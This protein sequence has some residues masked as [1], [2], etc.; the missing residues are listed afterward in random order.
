M[1]VA[2][3]IALKLRYDRHPDVFCTMD[4]N[5][6]LR[7]TKPDLMPLSRSFLVGL[8]KDP[9]FFYKKKVIDNVVRDIYAKCCAEAVK[10]LTT[11]SFRPVLPRTFHDA[12]LQNSIED[13]P[14]IYKTDLME[15]LKEVFPDSDIRYH[16][17]V[18]HEGRIVESLIII[19]WT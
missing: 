13:Y 12:N 3:W 2:A 16:E 19:D 5:Q 7:D 10:G 8:Q 15:A 14:T 9:H 1:F 18:G 4:A 11:Y 17:T 6:Y